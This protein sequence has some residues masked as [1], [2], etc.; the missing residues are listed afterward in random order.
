VCDG[1]D[2]V[3]FLDYPSIQVNHFALA[4]LSRRLKV[5]GG[6]TEEVQRFV[7]SGVWRAA[8]LL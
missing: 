4:G 1:L 6:A 3:E 5:I 2:P 7:A 8:R